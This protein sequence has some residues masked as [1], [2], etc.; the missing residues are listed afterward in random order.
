MRIRNKPW[1]LDF[2]REQTV[3]ELSPEQ[4]KGKWKAHMKR[5]SLYIE[6]GA[7]KGDFWNGM[8]DHHPDQAW[9]AIEKDK[10]VSVTAV[11]KAAEKLQDNRMWVLSDADFL[12]DYFAEKEVNG[13]YLNFSDP[14][15]KKRNSKRRLTHYRFLETYD[16]I[17]MDSGCLVMK[18]DNQELFEY[19]LCQFSLAHWVLS[20][21]SLDYINS[22]DSNDVYTEYERKFVKEGKRIYRAIWKKDVNEK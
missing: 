6:I 12:E 7:G 13:I 1:A 8:A 18:T 3:V 10:N 5:E 9:V 4:L 22:D 17:L 16:K 21:L 19:S 15:P 11:S 14:W 2:L 20:E